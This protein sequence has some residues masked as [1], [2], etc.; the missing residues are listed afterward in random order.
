[1]PT[2]AS[3]G[4][5]RS[6]AAVGRI[7]PT[8]FVPQHL[9]S[10]LAKALAALC[11]VTIA[12]GQKGPPLAPLHLVPAA[13]TDLALRRVD[14]QAHLRFVLPTRNANG[15]G[16]LELDHI[17]VYAITVPPGVTPPNRVLLSKAYMIGQMPVRPAP[18]EGEPPAE[19][20]SR[21]GPGEAVTFDEALTPEKLKPVELET[22]DDEP[23][24]RGA[25]PAGAGT[26]APGAAAT[27]RPQPAAGTAETAPLTAG[28]AA[29]AQTTPATPA[30][31]TPAAPTP[32]TPAAPTQATPGTTPQP[33][34][35]KP[36]APAGSKAK[37][38]P[39]KPT[40][41]V[42]VYVIRGV[43]RSG[44]FGPPSARVQF[45]VVPLPAPPEN[46]TT[47]LTEKAV[48]LAW[49]PSVEAPKAA[50]NVYSASD[51]IKP[52]NPAPLTTPKFEHA[53][54]AIGEEQCYSVR[55]VRA[56]GAVPLE[57][58]PSEPVCVTPKDTFAPAAP[59]GLAAVPTPGQISLIWD[60][61][62]EADLAGY[63][64]MRGEAGGG[65][66]QPLTPKPIRETSYRDS[67]VTAGVRYVYAIVAVDGA[68][69]PN[70]SD[71]SARVEE[72]AR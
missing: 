69:P 50:F 4:P 54:A 41:P 16:R 31:T 59:K 12:C 58:A 25:K 66:L 17:E 2:P 6:P 8:A 48:V 9:Q 42:R 40:D 61:N 53:V 72:I 19:G 3:P 45:P 65:E 55:S 60:A 30:Q 10:R 44:R 18:I 56:A 52:L 27:P 29:P 37:P 26:T 5:R 49:K 62:T 68:T 38:A 22:E 24:G 11:L 67:T 28:A 33:P 23:A 32:T 57:G 70:T 7:R 43:T 21:P 13:V 64:V 46:L 15:P 34:P 14:D 36:G 20:D 63:L 51:T 47:T 71:P 1:M 35:A 39:P